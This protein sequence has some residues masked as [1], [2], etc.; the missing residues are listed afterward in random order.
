MKKKLILIADDDPD[1]TRLLSLE[2]QDHGYDVITASTGREAVDSVN[3]YRP[4]L[5]ILDYQMPEG[6]GVFVMSRLRAVLETFTIP[7]I[8][9]TAYET[10]KLRR[11]VFRLSASF[12]ISKPYKPELLLEKIREIL[13]EEDLPSDSSLDR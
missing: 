1:F 12:V 11:E 10:R 8:L 7:I 4:D 3:Q 5:V 13:G 2:L 6:D 9:L